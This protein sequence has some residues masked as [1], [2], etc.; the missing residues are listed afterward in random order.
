MSG[1]DVNNLRG[2]DRIRK[3][4]LE[5]LGTKKKTSK[6]V[7]PKR[8]KKTTKTRLR[9]SRSGGKKSSYEKYADEREGTYNIWSYRR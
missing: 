6:G 3:K 5:G 4:D 8:F 1:L 7:P 2:D 9:F